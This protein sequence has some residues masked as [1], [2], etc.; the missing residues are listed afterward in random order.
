MEISLSGGAVLR[1]SQ[2]HSKLPLKKNEIDWS[3]VTRVRIFQIEVVQ[4]E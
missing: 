1:F 3:K 4:D 2:N